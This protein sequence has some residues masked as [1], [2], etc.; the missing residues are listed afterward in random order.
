MYRQTCK[1]KY[2]YLYTLIDTIF[3][4]YIYIPRQ[5]YLHISRE[6]H[7]KTSQQTG[8]PVFQC[9]FRY[10]ETHMYS[11]IWPNSRARIWP[12][13]C[14]VRFLIFSLDQFDML[15][16]A[17]SNQVVEF[18]LLEPSVQIHMSPLPAFHIQEEIVAL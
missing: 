10:S 18:F 9:G 15:F 17:F 13:W 3:H 12:N 4:I 14:F 1:F 6:I 8:N 11:Q 7:T 16:I 5:I 2:S